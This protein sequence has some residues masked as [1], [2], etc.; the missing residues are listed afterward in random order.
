MYPRYSGR[1]HGQYHRQNKSHP[2]QTEAQTLEMCLHGSKPRRILEIT[3]AGIRK[4]EERLCTAKNDA[5]DLVVN[6]CP[7]YSTAEFIRLAKLMKDKKVHDSVV[8]WVFTNRSVYAWIKDNGILSDLTAAG[9]TVFTDGCPLQYPRETWQFN[10]A[11]SDSVKFAN[12]CFSQRGLD[13]VYGSI[14]DCVE[15]ALR[16][17][18]CRKKS[19]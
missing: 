11:M 1:Q 6:G 15:T 3:P 9:V 8:F 16:G 10:A 14:E 5:V 17:K 2:L 12:Y 19:W 7:H 4:A 18:L 13:A